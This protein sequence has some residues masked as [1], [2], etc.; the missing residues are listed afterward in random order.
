MRTTLYPAFHHEFI[1]VSGE[2][3]PGLP[4][5][6]ATRDLFT[7]FD[8]ALQAH[9]LSLEDTVRTRLWGRSRAARD[10]GSGE[11]VK[12]LAG[13]ARSA[14]SSYI[15]PGHFDSAGAVAVDLWAMRG[16]TG[17]G[18]IAWRGGEPCRCH[19]LR[20]DRGFRRAVDATRMRSLVAGPA[21]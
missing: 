13:K 10:G 11:R 3:R 9:G 6:E 4:P 16:D 1:A 20:H 19:R 2:S 8:T 15:F 17:R 7:R 14:S 5:N 12:M 21:R 18:R